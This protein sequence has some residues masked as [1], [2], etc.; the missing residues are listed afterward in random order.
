MSA[1]AIIAIIDVLFVVLLVLGFLGGFCRGVK[2]SLLEFGLA[3]AGIVICGFITPV[4]TNAILGITVTANG[5]STSL[6]TFFVNI[7]AE[8][9]TLATLLESSPS[10]AGLLQNLPQVLF[11]SV[12]FLALNL[13]MRVIMYIIYK[14]ISVCA[15]KSKKKEK[16]LGLKRKRWLGGLIG[17]VKMFMVVLVIFMPVVSLVRLVDNNLPAEP[18]T[19][20]AATIIDGDENSGD[21]NQNTNTQVDVVVPPIVKNILHGINKSA[22]GVVGGC[23]GL[24]DYIFDN[25]SQFELNGQKIQVRKEIDTYLT[26]YKDISAFDINTEKVKDLDW[27]ALDRLYNTISSS[28]FY[29]GFVLNAAGELI[30]N[31]PKIIALFP[32]ELGQFE[33]IF[34]GIKDGMGEEADYVKY[35]S[36]DIDKLYA[37]FS[38]LGKSGYVDKVSGDNIDFAEELTILATE[39]EELLTSTISNFFDINIIR[40]A[41]SPTL[42]FALTKVGSSDIGDIFKEANTEITDWEGLKTQLKTL[43]VDFGTVNNLIKDQNNDLAI[44]ISDIISNVKLALKLNKNVPEILSEFGEMLDTANNMAI[45]ENNRGEKILPL[46]LE[47]FGVK[48]LLVVNGKE[49]I[50]TYKKLFEYVGPA[51]ENIISLDLYDDVANG[52]EMNALLKK[53]ATRLVS[54]MKVVEGK[55][56]YSTFMTDTILPLYSVKGFRDVAFGPIIDASKDTGVVDFSLLEVEGD[57]EASYANWKSDLEYITQVITELENKM[58]DETENKTCL[59]YILAGGD[60][61]NV[62]N[63]LTAEGKA[64]A[65]VDPIMK[66]KSTLP[67]KQKLA[68]S[69]I[70]KFVSG[71]V[72]TAFTDV[73]I[74]GLEDETT[75]QNVANAIAGNEENIVK[76]LDKAEE[77]GVK[78][79]LSKEAADTLNEK[80]NALENVEQET[81]NKLKDFFGI[82][83]NN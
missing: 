13:V 55:K 44:S 51:A 49:D 3:F 5:V 43:V 16:E 20:S 32:D 58:Y 38:E 17:T 45:M 40:D 59:D 53:F 47:K 83:G 50:D 36:N 9:P 34:E 24:D 79:E 23:V 64:A 78:M 22:F 39:H 48:D 72:A 26:I 11:C 54:D 77:Y 46:V 41:F 68:E 21:E 62:V 80:L 73:I 74:N 27:D 61:N 67:L 1:V 33:Q 4:V 8:D 7:M 25:I 15:F 81:I 75:L 31:Y 65:V 19:A 6:K 35:F 28:G 12:V 18:N 56:T 2:R 60:I 69:M 30:Y 52:L 10:L 71:D 63:I 70:N 29:K 37:I 42:D 14:I 66:A 82:G 76:V 57:F